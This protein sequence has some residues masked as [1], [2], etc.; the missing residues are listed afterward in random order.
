MARRPVTTFQKPLET[1][2]KAG[3]QGAVYQQSV[4][5]APGPY[6]LKILARDAISGRLSTYE[7]TLDVPQFDE[8]KLA[9]SSLILA[10]TVERL[11]VN[12]PPGAMF[13][14]GGTVVRPRPGNRFTGDEKLGIYLQ[15][16]NFRPDVTAGKLSGSIEYEIDNAGSN[17]KVIDFSE[18]AGSIAN[19]SSSQVTIEKLVSLKTFQPGSYTLKVTA[20]DRIG[21]QTLRQQGNFTVS[22]R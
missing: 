3:Q 5:L 4:P 10:D 18:E 15:L 12:S 16:Y 21:N 11:P 19:A 1:D 20:T 9:S 22:N 6:R 8:G 13:M 7:V 14:I 17:E 2:A